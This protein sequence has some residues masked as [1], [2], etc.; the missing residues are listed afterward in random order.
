MRLDTLAAAS[1]DLTSPVKDVVAG[2]EFVAGV[3]SRI[4]KRLK[5]L[6]DKE[7]RVEGE[8]KEDEEKDKVKVLDFER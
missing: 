3:A 1:F 4:K 2:A 5:M 7:V 6:R 8:E